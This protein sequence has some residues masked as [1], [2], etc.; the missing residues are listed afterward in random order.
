MKK[1][2]VAILIIFALGLAWLNFP[3]FFKK[4]SSVLAVGSTKGEK[5]AII[6]QEKPFDAK[7]IAMIRQ[8]EH[9]VVVL[10]KAG[11]VYAAGDNN[12]GQLGVGFFGTEKLEELRKVH[13]PGSV[14]VKE[15]DTTAKHVIALTDTGDVWAW[16]MNISGQIGDGS[17]VDRSVPVKVLGGAVTIAAGHRFS[18]ALK[19]NG[20]L[21]AWGM[22]CSPKT[23][24]LA[25]LAA[26]F[27]NSITAGGGY[28]GGTTQNDAAYC[29]EEQNL[30]IASTTPR[31]IDS[32]VPFVS[33]S[34]GY[35]HLLMIDRNQDAWSFGCNAWGQLGRGYAY[36]SGGTR[37]ITR[38]NFPPGVKV[39]QLDAGFRHSMA[40]D[41]QNR[42][43][44][45][46]YDLN[47]GTAVYRAN[48]TDALKQVPT[49]LRV[50]A[51]EAGYDI[52]GFLTSEGL[53]VRGETPQSPPIV[54]DKPTGPSFHK[55]SGKAVAFSLGYTQHFYWLKP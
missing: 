48:R 20:E 31:K 24:G 18:A 7:D 45:W 49:T 46:G 13:L 15:I 22:H 38:V 47:D 30:P 50:E 28:Y 42:V 10:T 35:G 6:Q 43:W 27:A 39:V 4:P 55:V 5:L 25:E 32:P 3:T 52:S 29:L 23:P 19:K 8:G 2:H 12:H 36:N 1:P 51:I 33:V 11:T 21:W 9:S 54:Q 37:K 14:K 41:T 40:L 17:N 16:G 26:Q 44:A 53:F 34:G